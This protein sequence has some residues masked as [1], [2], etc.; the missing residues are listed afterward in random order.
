M[1]V[2]SFLTSAGL[3]VT[4]LST[5]CAAAWWMGALFSRVKAIQDRLESFTDETH[6]QVREISRQASKLDA[7]LDIQE[8][9]ITVVEVKLQ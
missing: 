6:E 4:I 2:Q 7:R 3:I 1:E 9:R 5:V 8:Q